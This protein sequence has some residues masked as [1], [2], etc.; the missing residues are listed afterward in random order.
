MFYNQGLLTSIKGRLNRYCRAHYSMFVCLISGESHELECFEWTES[1]I[2]IITLKIE[3]GQASVLSHLGSLYV[4]TLISMIEIWR[5]CMLKTLS[6]SVFDACHISATCVSAPERCFIYY[7]WKCLYLVQL[8]NFLELRHVL[9][10]YYMCQKIG[11][12]S[13]KSC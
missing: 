12:L 4:Y 11:L 5:A 1:N 3:Y 13:M 2:C 10:R 6:Y 8:S 9:L 7:R